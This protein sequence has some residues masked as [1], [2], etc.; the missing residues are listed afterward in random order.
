M[1]SYVGKKMQYKIIIMTQQHFKTSLQMFS[2]TELFLYL[3]QGIL[4]IRG[5]WKINL[6]AM[7][8]MNVTSWN[9]SGGMAVKEKKGL[10]L[11][12]LRC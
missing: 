1:C 5:K 10:F 6:E 7:R 3:G 9:C 11:V 2:E 4:C 12:G 8:E